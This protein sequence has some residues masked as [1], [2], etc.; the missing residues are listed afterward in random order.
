MGVSDTKVDAIWQ[1]RSSPLYSPAERIALEVA[2]AAGG[3]PNGV[4]DEMFDEL[5][6]HWDEEQIVE[7]IGVIALFGFLN[8]WNDTMASPLEPDSI[9]VAERLLAPHGWEIGK[10]AP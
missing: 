4:T 3:V 5:K 8:R 9:G 10:N 1:F 6:R 2:I 7:I